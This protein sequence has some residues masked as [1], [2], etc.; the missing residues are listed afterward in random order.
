MTLVHLWQYFPEFFL[1]WEMF[2]T[3]IVEEIKTYT[4]CSGTSFQKSCHLWD[5]VEKYGTARQTTNDTVI[6][7]I[8]FACWITKAT[9]T[10]SKYV[11]HIDFPQHEW[12]CEHARKLHLHI[13]CPSC[14]SSLIMLLITITVTPTKTLHRLCKKDQNQVRWKLH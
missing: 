6:C 8:C 5:N 13:H 2:Q 14:P 11:I 12:L 4:L 3:K 1:E 7:C 9:D 10:H